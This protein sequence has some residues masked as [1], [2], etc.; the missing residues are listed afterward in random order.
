M[1]AFCY[2]RWARAQVSFSLSLSLSY[3]G[4]E[5]NAVFLLRFMGS[6][7][8][9]RCRHADPICSLSWSALFWVFIIRVGEHYQGTEGN[10]GRDWAAE[11]C[12]SHFGFRGSS[13]NTILTGTLPIVFGFRGGWER[14]KCKNYTC[15]CVR[16]LGNL[17]RIFSPYDSQHLREIFRGCEGCSRSMDIQCL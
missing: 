11:R 16:S 10:F 2:G 3:P 4:H 8:V 9:Q 1:Q 7:A 6:G 13:S 15:G 14:K 17:F 5:A 12:S